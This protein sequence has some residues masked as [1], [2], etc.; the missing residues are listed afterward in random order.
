MYVR[1]FPK[2]THSTPPRTGSGSLKIRARRGKIHLIHPGHR[3]LHAH[4]NRHTIHHQLAP[5]RGKRICTGTRQPLDHRSHGVHD[6]ITNPGAVRNSSRTNLTNK[7][8]H[9]LIPKY[10]VSTSAL[11]LN[12]CLHLRKLITACAP[13]LRHGP[14]RAFH[15]EFLP[16]DG[17]DGG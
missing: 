14:S 1:A 10:H 12:N 15:V 6:S 17:M 9:S 16:E 3:L 8:G 7:K 5:L 13:G 4:P 2:N 11:F